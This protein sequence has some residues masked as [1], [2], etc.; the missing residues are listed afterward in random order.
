M[1]S[2]IIEKVVGA[3]PVASE[4][5][6]LARCSAGAGIDTEPQRLIEAIGRA[7]AGNGGAR[8]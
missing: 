2:E 4:D 3:D 8:P 5:A 1:V 7:D 6:L